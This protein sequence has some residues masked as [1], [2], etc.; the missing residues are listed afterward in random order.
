MAKH[1]FIESKLLFLDLSYF[2]M[3]LALFFYATSID[4]NMLWYEIVYST[5]TQ[6]FDK[7]LKSHYKSQLII[8][9]EF[10]MQMQTRA[11]NEQAINDH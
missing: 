2:S 8:A 11:S 1:R 5:V 3:P 10:S 7:I 4:V 6:S 9:D